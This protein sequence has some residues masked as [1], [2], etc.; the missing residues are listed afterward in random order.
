M[1]ELF[2]RL[3]HTIDDACRFLDNL[4]YTFS[5]NSS[6]CKAGYLFNLGKFERNTRIF[7]RIEFGLSAKNLDE[8]SINKI[9]YLTFEKAFPEH[10]TEIHK[11]KIKRNQ[12][13]KAEYFNEKET[14][15]VPDA[16]EYVAEEMDSPENAH[17]KNSPFPWI[18]PISQWGAF[19][20]YLTLSQDKYSICLYR[21]DNEILLW[22][23]DKMRTELQSESFQKIDW[24]KKFSIKILPKGIINAASNKING[25][26]ENKSINP[27]WKYESAVE[28]IDYFITFKKDIPP[29]ELID[30]I[31]NY[32]NLLPNAN[33]EAKPYFQAFQEMERY[34]DSIVTDLDEIV[35][36]KSGIDNFGIFEKS[37][38]MHINKKQG[39]ALK[40]IDFANM[41]R[42]SPPP[43]K[44]IVRKIIN[45]RH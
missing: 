5:L 41:W 34:F 44:S 45:H 15:Q 37:I 43:D 16:K 6:S 27:N 39:M 11:Y 19:K 29:Q 2:N 38:V 4:P 13:K 28:L 21:E 36:N 26:G 9:F 23:I 20:N 7:R 17:Y 10:K 24:A 40:N 42:S 22:N 8:I 31:H 18:D 32:R 1:I 30:I 25:A 14:I 3:I 12:T 33:G 35:Y